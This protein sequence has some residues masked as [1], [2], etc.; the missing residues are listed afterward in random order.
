MKIHI[1][2]IK[3][4]PTPVCPWL[5]SRVHYPLLEPFSSLEFTRPCTPFYQQFSSKLMWCRDAN[6]LPVHQAELPQTPGTLLLLVPGL[7]GSAMPTYLVL[8]P[9]FM[10]LL[11][12]RYCWIQLPDLHQGQQTVPDPVWFSPVCVFPNLQVQARLHNLCTSP[13]CYVH[14]RHTTNSR[15][16]YA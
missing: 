1:P 5:L 4:D 8:W 3:G 16:I 15:S 9:S 10:S 7:P 13:V 6:N 14:L 12:G 2:R 11:G